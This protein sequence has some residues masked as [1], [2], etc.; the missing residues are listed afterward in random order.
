MVLTPISG[1]K[2]ASALACALGLTAQ[3]PPIRNL[4]EVLAGLT[5][6]LTKYLDILVHS[7]IAQAREVEQKIASI[8]QQRKSL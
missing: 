2:T 1:S 3:L 4:P 8:E 5:E 6:Q 7:G